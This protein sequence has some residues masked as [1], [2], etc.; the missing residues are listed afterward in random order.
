MAEKLAVLGPPGTHSEAAARYLNGLLG[1][2]Y[3]QEEYEEIYDALRAAAVGETAA[4]FVPV[5]NSLEGAINVTLD[6]LAATDEL[7]VTR[8]IVWSVKN[9]LAAKNAGDIR[10]IYSHAQPISQCQNYLRQHFSH[11]EIVKV[12][13]TAKAAQI[14]GAADVGAAAIC[15]ARAAELNGLKVIAE[16]IEDTDA[17]CTRFFELRRTPRNGYDKY[18]E[19]RGDKTLIICRIDGRT[20]GSLLKVLE[21]FAV[22][23]VNLT[24]IE[25]RPARTQLGEYIFFFDVESN[26]D[27]KTRD[28]AIEAVAK[29]SLWLKNVGTFRVTAANNL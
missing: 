10:K 20:A 1:G 5:E 16:N 25:S 14:V 9:I 26:T 15:T 22:R 27:K 29:R 24:R 17:N 7:K 18:N 6:F 23:G 28:E 13:S 21:E 11:A 3:E 2:I 19:E 12:S 4:A 8:E